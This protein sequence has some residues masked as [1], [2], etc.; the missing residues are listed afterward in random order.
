MV[1]INRCAKYICIT[2]LAENDVNSVE[3]LACEL[4]RVKLVAVYCHYAATGEARRLRAIDRTLRLPLCAYDG[5][6]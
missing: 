6:C 3:W 4:I 5:V 1:A 2:F